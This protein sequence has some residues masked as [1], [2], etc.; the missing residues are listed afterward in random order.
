MSSKDEAFLQHRGCIVQGNLGSR[1]I[2]WVRLA[3]HGTNPLH[4]KR[5]TCLHHRL[6]TRE[7]CL[8]PA[9]R[10]ALVVDE[11]A[12]SFRLVPIIIAIGFLPVPALDEGAAVDPPASARMS[13][14][15]FSR[16]RER[17]CE[18]SEHWSKTTPAE[19]L[20]FASA[21]SCNLAILCTF[22]QINGHKDTIEV[23]KKWA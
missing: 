23:G 12:G 3:P 5:S 11:E 17:L 9:T 18:A 20:C 16:L 6:L 10:D 13:S 15:L 21:S 19:D 2:C 22:N 8:R 14:S 1:H 7:P 4:H